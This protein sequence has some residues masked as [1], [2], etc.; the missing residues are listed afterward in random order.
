MSQGP[1]HRVSIDRLRV[2]LFIELDLG[3]SEHPFTFSAFRIKSAEQI[4][5]LRQLGLR[6]VRFDP[7]RSVVQPLA[8]STAATVAPP[9]VD[10]T[11]DVY[12]AQRGRREQLALQQRSLQRAE[13]RFDEAA[14]ELRQVALEVRAQPLSAGQRSDA[15]AQSLCSDMLGD[16]QVSIRLL[17][18]RAGDDSSLHALNVCVLSL[19]LGR[20]VGLGTGSLRELAI[21]AL[22]HDVG[23]LQLPGRLR[24]AS[25]QLTTAERKAVEEHPALGAA[26]VEQMELPRAVQALVAEH[27]ERADGSGYPQRL[28]GL[29]LSPPARVLTLV[30][31][32]DNL[33]NTSN[34]AN[35]LTPH[36]ALASIYARD[37]GRFDAPTLALF[38]RMMGIYPPGSVLQL[39][40]GRYALS[41]A[42]NASEP[43]KPQVLIHDPQVPP[44]QATVIE[45]EHEPGLEVERAL[46]PGALPRAVFEYLSPRKR[47]SFF[48]EPTPLR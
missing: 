30:N 46:K 16:R 39:S 17:S 18:E 35:A 45:L 8:E 36:E 14:R 3:W 33:C 37:Q 11:G 34:A 22:L 29:Q 13:R 6:E 48:F 44:E 21:A 47:Q 23:K 9:D 10:A 26:M 24:W 4:E 43:R 12:C 40:D 1:T 20:A 42:V 5:A 31:H 32:Y 19:L 27:H 28:R 25:D 38:V 2:G 15:L 7:R 41:V